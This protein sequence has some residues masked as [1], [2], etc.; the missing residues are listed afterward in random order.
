M[1]GGADDA[2]GA[3]AAALVVVAGRPAAE[4][5]VVGAVEGG[6]EGVDAAGV[7]DEGVLDRTALSSSATMTL[8]R[9]AS[10]FATACSLVLAATSS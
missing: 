5:G 4:A 3:D 7:V 8:L 9:R 2:E 10:R 1:V 6:A